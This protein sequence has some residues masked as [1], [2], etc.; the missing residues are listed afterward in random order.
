M[1]MKNNLRRFTP[2]IAALGFVVAPMVGCN[3]DA[4]PSS[5]VEVAPT[6]PRATE[7]GVPILDKLEHEVDRDVRQTAREVKQEVDGDK[8]DLKA[9]EEDLKKSTERTVDNLLGDPK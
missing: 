9:T 6:P 4:P 8:R 3:S 5:V 2:A 7:S 1:M